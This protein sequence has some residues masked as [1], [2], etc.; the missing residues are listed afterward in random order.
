[1]KNVFSRTLVG[2]ACL[3]LLSFVA[4]AQKHKAATSA[5]GDPVGVVVL[6]GAGK[7]G[8]IVVGSAARATWWASKFVA[9]DVAK[10]LAASVLQPIV[11]KAAPAVAKFAFKNSIKYLLPFAAKLSLL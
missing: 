4:F 1:M 2:C 3:L 6:K 7:T 11:T 9:K 5:G 10:P 8:V